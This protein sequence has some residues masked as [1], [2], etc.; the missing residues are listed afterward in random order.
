[1]STLN[2][3]EREELAIRALK[4]KGLVVQI[5]DFS[6]EIDGDSV[7]VDQPSKES[8]DDRSVSSAT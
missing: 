4:L 5:P 2:A 3:Q 8:F 1:M 6:V 7:E